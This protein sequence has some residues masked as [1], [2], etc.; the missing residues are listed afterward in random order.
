[1]SVP[2]TDV[3]ELSNQVSSLRRAIKIACAVLVFA[4]IYLLYWMATVVPRTEK[5]INEMLGGA[6]LPGLTKFTF[7]LSS[8]VASN[9]IYLLLFF[10]AAY[11]VYIKF[12]QR[13]RRAWY[14]YVALGALVVTPI[15]QGVMSL[16]LQL[17]FVK[18][19][20]LMNEQSLPF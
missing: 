8:F 1:M 12:M 5:I 20:T 14:V 10:V 9:S 3:E 15:L 2:N 7:W 6:E 13:S 19:S 4:P 18:I 16:G 17:P 11:I